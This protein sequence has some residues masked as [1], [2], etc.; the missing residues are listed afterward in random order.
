MTRAASALNTPA[1]G[2]TRASQPSPDSIGESSVGHQ[3]LVAGAAVMMPHASAPRC[4]GVGA[5]DRG[6]SL[7]RSERPWLRGL[8]DSPIGETC[9]RLH[10]RASPRTEFQTGG[11]GALAT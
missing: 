7:R 2:F 3:P 6:E 1:L 10:R 11:R 5:T 9:R 4:F 8:V